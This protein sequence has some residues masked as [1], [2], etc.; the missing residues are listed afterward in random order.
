MQRHDRHRLFASFQMRI[1]RE[2]KKCTVHTENKKKSKTEK[3]AKHSEARRQT[4]KQMDE[5][6]KKYIKE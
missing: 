6:E 4:D 5:N 1:L 3:Y 2:N